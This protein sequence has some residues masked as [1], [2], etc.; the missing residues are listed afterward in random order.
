VY[1]YMYLCV[2]IYMCTYTYMQKERKKERKKGRHSTRLGQANSLL[3]NRSINEFSFSYPA[4]R[5]E[6]KA[7]KEKKK[8]EKQQEADSLF[9]KRSNNKCA[10][11]ESCHELYH[12]QVVRRD[13][14]DCRVRHTL[15][16][17][18]MVKFV[19]H[20]ECAGCVEQ[21]I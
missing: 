3:I 7:R 18:V 16:T 8:K 20:N 11:V 15:L 5:L 6:H 17:H 4:M 12:Q 21:N 10:L 14:Y 9:I 2:C 13:T 19:T 1:I